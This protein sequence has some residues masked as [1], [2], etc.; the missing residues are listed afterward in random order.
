MMRRI[1]T[2][3]IIAL[4]FAFTALATADGESHHAMQQ[5]HTVEA[6]DD[7]ECIKVSNQTVTV[8]NLSSAPCVYS[9]YCVTGQAVKTLRL[10]PGTHASFDLPKGF[11]V[12]KCNN[13][14]SRKII[15]R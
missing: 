9:V 7:A 8:S 13:E 11:Y 3:A 6:A 5:R 12:V 1:F 10:A 2:I 14:W 15:V 4:N